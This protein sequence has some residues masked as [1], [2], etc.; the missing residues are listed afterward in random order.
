MIKLNEILKSYPDE[1]FIKA[2]GF[3]DAVVGIEVNSLR[4]VYSIELAVE[5]LMRKNIER[6]DALEHLYYKVIPEQVGEKSPIW[7]NILF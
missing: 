5:S 1:E 2:D 3:D 4:L 7:I 6:D